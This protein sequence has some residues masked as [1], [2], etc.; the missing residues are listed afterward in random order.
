VPENGTTPIA[1]VH[2]ANELRRGTLGAD[3]WWTFTLPSKYL[4]KVHDYVTGEDH[5]GPDSPTHEKGKERET[6]E[7]GDDDGRRSVK[8]ERRRS[9][10]ERI[11]SLD[12]E[13]QEYHR[14]MSMSMG[15]RLAPNVFSINQTQVRRNARPLTSAFEML[16]E[17]STY[18]D[19][20]MVISVDSVPP[21]R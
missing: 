16:T 15:T 1:P 18:I 5:H 11:K 8:E 9:K 20:R 7:E 21:R 12:L 14:N 6:R 10:H 13:K 2:S 4:D 17:L 19:P 3:R